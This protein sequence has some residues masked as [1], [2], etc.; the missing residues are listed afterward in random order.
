[1]KENC[2]IYQLITK[3]FK[4]LI[5]Y[6]DKELLYGIV[7]MFMKDN[8]KMMSNM[9]M[10]NII[11]KMVIIIKDNGLMIREMDMVSNYSFILQVFFIGM[12]EENIKENGKM[13]KDMDQEYFI[14]KYIEQENM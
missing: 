9:D 12:M 3:V 11:I 4:T 13:I 1:M 6:M 5:L 8:G 10:E 14:C 7:E 2:K